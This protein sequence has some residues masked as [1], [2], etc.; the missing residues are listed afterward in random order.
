MTDISGKA[1]TD[2]QNLETLDATEQGV[3]RTAIGATEIAAT[4]IADGT[5]TTP[6]M[7]TGRRARH[8]VNE[9]NLTTAQAT[10]ETSTVKGTITG[11]RLSEAVAEFAPEG[12]P[13]EQRR[14]SITF[15]AVTAAIDTGTVVSPNTAASA[16][17][18][19]FPTGE[20]VAEIIEA[21]SNADGF[22]ILKA[23]MYLITWES[24]IDNNPRTAPAAFIYNY[25]D[26]PGTDAPIGFTNMDYLRYSVTNSATKQIGVLQV[27]ADDT[28]VKL[29]V[30]NPHNTAGAYGSF[31]LEANATLT[32]IRV[33]VKGDAG[34]VGP[35]GVS[36]IDIHD[37]L[38]NE[39]AAPDNADRIAIS[40]EG[41]AGDPTEYIEVETLATFFND[42]HDR[43]TNQLSS[44]NNVDR[45]YATDEGTI[46]DPPRYITLSDLAAFT[47]DIKDRL[48]T[49][50]TT[51]SDDDRI[52]ITDE[53]A[54]GDPVR[55][56]SVE[57]LKDALGGGGGT[58]ASIWW[59][60]VVITVRLRRNGCRYH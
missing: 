40:D 18:I 13:D 1:D 38:S 11:E 22:D 60:T 49:E 8:L 41:D 52:L 34:G 32:L 46:G 53:S 44:P 48:G 43:I 3:V 42:F 15:Q 37:N 47:L 5:D 16:I 20:T 14:E 25:A 6:G 36:T 2:L 24:D 23:G 35:S 27:D 28:E 29:V 39:M 55:W 57:T 7:I 9:V 33:G 12:S 31:T 58:P 21:G 4:D 56:A 17:S 45:L 10:D 51:I 26:T 30:L 50:L 54:P 59:M 19:D